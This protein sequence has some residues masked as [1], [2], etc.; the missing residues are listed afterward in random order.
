MEE[1]NCRNCGAP[2]NKNGD[3]EYCGT[4][5]TITDYESYIKITADSIMIGT[6][7][8]DPLRHYVKF[9]TEG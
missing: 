1:K 5:K 6:M 9:V 8:S 3:C 4:V 7:P 2:L